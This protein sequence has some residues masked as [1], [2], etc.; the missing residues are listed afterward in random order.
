MATTIKL[1]N[2]S[3]APLAGDLVQG[4]PALDL[5]NKRLYTE[6]SG[7]TIIEV[8]TNPTSLTTGT[9][10]STGIDDNATSTAITIDASEN[11]GIGVT[12][13]TTS[14]G[15][16]LEIG[17]IGNAVWGAGVDNLNLLSNLY[18]D[19]GYKYANTDE[20]AQLQL[21][22][23]KLR[24]YNAASGTADTAATLT[25]RFVIDGSGNVGIGTTSPISLGAGYKNLDIRHSTGGGVTLGDTSSVHG[26]LFSDSSGLTLQAP[27]SRT[28]EFMT[29]SSER[30]RIDSAGQTMIQGSATAFDTTAAKNGLQLYYETDTG[31]ATL[32]SYSSGGTT[33]M[34]FHTNSGG[35]A[36]AERM[37]I[38]GSGNV[39]VGGTTAGNA[40]SI[41]ITAGSPGSTV[42]GLQLWSTTAGSHFVQFGDTASGNGYYRGA[43]GYLHAS[44]ALVAYSAGSERMRIT[45]AGNVGIGTT[46][47]NSAGNYY[48]GWGLSLGANRTF[49]GTTSSGDSVLGGASGSAFTAVYVN[50]AEKMRLTNANKAGILTT[51]PQAEFVVSNVSN[52]RNIEMGY[53]AGTAA[54]YLQSYDRTA[55]AYYDMELYHNNLM[56]HTGSSALERMRINSSGEVSIGTTTATSGRALTLDSTSN[57]FGIE[58]QQGGTSRGRIIQES[59]GNMYYDANSNLIFRTNTTTERARFNSS[60][61][62]L[63]GQTSASSAVNGIYL[64]PGVASGFVATND[65]ALELFRYSSNGQIVKIYRNTTLVGSI[66][67]TTSS[68]AYNTSSDERLKE[69]IVDAPAGNI[70]DIRVR[71]FDWKADGSHQTYG[72]VAQELVDVAP[73]AVTQGET[74]DDMWA[75]DYSK[76]VPMMIKEIQ[77]LKAEVAALK[78]A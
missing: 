3:G 35:S 47:P 21:N 78:G 51:S 9:F 53:S 31:V 8:G 66:S 59:T 12:P 76:L 72:M 58:F 22:A 69:N 25:E 44:D 13:S 20:A 14:L 43:V 30:M 75:V 41:V 24:F 60:G 42:G 4:E 64:R 38:D 33:A 74:E 70:D 68:T 28:L 10:T 52:E 62:L 26:Y 18:Y 54:N 5:T 19:T 16:I 71:S 27:G 23:G 7:G 65:N 77:D 55:S 67:V 29:G 1:K 2:G 45:A 17:D 39:T 61:H 40:G 49:I 57:Y 6:D 50:A 34:T 46:S 56:I 32:G 37:R 36:S 11:V 63:I 73:E 48:D 15:T